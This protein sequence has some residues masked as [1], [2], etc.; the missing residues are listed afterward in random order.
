MWWKTWRRHGGLRRPAELKLDLLR[1]LVNVKLSIL[2]DGVD[3][4]DSL[5]AP[6]GLDPGKLRLTEPLFNLIDF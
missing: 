3:L 6:T 5:I 4:L 2:H 1:E